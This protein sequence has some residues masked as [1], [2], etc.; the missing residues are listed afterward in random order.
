M[1]FYK[2]IRRAIVFLVVLSA[3]SNEAAQQSMQT[4][5]QTA[6]E[7]T[8][9]LI[10]K[11]YSKAYA[12]TSKQFQSTFAV[13]DMKEN[14]ERMLPKEFG[15]IGEIDI[16]TTMHNWPDKQANDLGWVYVSIGGDYWGEAVATVITMEDGQAKIRLIE[17][18]RP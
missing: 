9:V 1:Q 16:V 17:Y 18:G 14:V 3:C 15:K 4:A 2:T 6:L 13:S 10:G 12:M 8:R 11:D 5:E 7:F